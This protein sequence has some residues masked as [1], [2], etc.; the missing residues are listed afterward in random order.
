MNFDA[1]MRG[2]EIKAAL[3]HISENLLKTELC[4]RIFIMIDDAV[5][6]VNDYCLNL[7]EKAYINQ[8]YDT[9]FYSLDIGNGCSESLVRKIAEKGGGE[10]EL[11]KNEEDIS[12]KF[13]KLLYD[14]FI[15]KLKNNNDNILKKMGVPK[16][17]C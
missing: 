14:S 8:R 16:I 9:K 10:C 17:L 1:D 6:D 12:G 15:C 4:N 7:V 13:H 3:E 11:V 5:W 2:T